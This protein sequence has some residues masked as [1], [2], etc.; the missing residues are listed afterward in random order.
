MKVH[1]RCKK[2]MEKVVFSYLMET[3]ILV[4]SKEEKK[5]EKEFQEKKER[6]VWE[7]GKIINLSFKIDIFYFILI[8]TI[9]Q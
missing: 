2:L 3:I 5:K 7:H 1:S 6:Y 8:K 9:Y 4:N